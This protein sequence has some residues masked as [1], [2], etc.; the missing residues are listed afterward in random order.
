MADVTALGGSGGVIF[1]SPHG[2]AGWRFTT[3]G[4]LRGRASSADAA[5]VAIFEDF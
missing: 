4:M 5:E 2:D 1:V 3:P